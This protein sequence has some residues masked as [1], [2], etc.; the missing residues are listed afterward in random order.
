MLFEEVAAGVATLVS[1]ASVEVGEDGPQSSPLGRPLQSLG[2]RVSA[3]WLGGPRIA[4]SI[5][6]CVGEVGGR[7]GRDE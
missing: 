3:G 2:L 7:G 6:A 4:A 5:A 1:A